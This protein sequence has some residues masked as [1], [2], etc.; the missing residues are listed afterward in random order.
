M[1]VARDGPLVGKSVAEAG[2]RNLEGVFLAQVERN[3]RRIAPVEPTETLQA[4]DRLL[5][6][7]NVSKVLDLHRVRGLQSVAQQ[8]GLSVESGR[9]GPGP[10]FYEAVIGLSSPL[11]GQ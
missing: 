6:A 10:R 5:F 3:E 1:N 2:L 7:G 11:T 4:G 9:R 8:R